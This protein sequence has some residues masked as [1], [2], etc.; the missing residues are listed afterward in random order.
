MENQSQLSELEK[1][2][3]NKHLLVSRSEKNKPFKLRRDFSNIV[4][5]DKH[6]FLKRISILFSKHPEIDPDTFFRAPYKL[7][8]D[9]EY[10]GLDYFSTMRAVKSY[11]MYKKQIFLQDPD[12]QLE[13]VKESLRFI[14]NFCIENNLYFHQYPYHRSSDMFTWM[15]HYKQNKINVYSVMEFTNIFSSVKS[16]A[17]DVQKFFVSEFVEQFQSL[18]SLYNKS[19][20]LKPY[21]KKAFP[22]LS[23]FVEKQL[24][25]PT[26]QSNI[27]SNL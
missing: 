16:L 23:N 9:V 13:Q 4:N 8:P 10:F 18:Y 24:T 27:K 17:E 5:T 6:K 7:Y 14:A 15:Q 20:E 3:F 21:V 11:T 19:A 22:V 2:L 26:N 1:C 12:S 25:C